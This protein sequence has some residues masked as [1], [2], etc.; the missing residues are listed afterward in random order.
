[1]PALLFY[2]ALYAAIVTAGVLLW[3]RPGYLLCVL[4]L[5]AAPWLLYAKKQERIIFVV[6]MILGPAA[7]YFAIRSGAWSYHE[8]PWVIPL[9]LPPAWGLASLCFL[10]VTE[11]IQRLNPDSDASAG[12]R[13]I[14]E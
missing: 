5:A 13:K 7:E 12:T 3:D 8:S 4:L 6:A 11:A 9:W 14:V 10:K 1:M 2:F